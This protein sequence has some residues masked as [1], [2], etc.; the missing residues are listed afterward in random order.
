MPLSVCPWVKD[1]VWKE[2]KEFSCRAKKAINT[3]DKM[4]VVL[5]TSILGSDEGR[6]CCAGCC[7]P[8]REKQWQIGSP[9]LL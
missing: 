8:C 2:D 7:P 1:C 9:K 6:T 5:P 3:A 4:V